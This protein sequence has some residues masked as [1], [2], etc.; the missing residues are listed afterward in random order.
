M[1]GT[2]SRVALSS[3]L[4]ICRLQLYAIFVVRGYHLPILLIRYYDVYK[5]SDGG[6]EDGKRK[7]RERRMG[8]RK[9]MREEGR[10]GEGGGRGR[11]RREGKGKGRA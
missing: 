7:V 1:I 11:R 9:V 4:S 5:E 8:E 10:G 3:S 2:A 6:R